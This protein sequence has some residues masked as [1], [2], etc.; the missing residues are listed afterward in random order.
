MFNDPER[1]AT[2]LRKLSLL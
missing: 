2:S 1:C